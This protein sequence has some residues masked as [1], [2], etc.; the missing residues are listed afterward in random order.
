MKT[1]KFYEYSLQGYGC[2][3]RTIEINEIDIISETPVS[4]S[5]KNDKVYY[6]DDVG[7]EILYITDINEF[8]RRERNWYKEFTEETLRRHELTLHMAEQ[9]KK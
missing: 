9:Y 6:E 7:S 5:V 3:E 1:I 4:V 8:I 2:F